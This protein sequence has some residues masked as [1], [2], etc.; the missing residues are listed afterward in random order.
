MIPIIRNNYYIFYIVVVFLKGGRDL[1]KMRSVQL[2]NDYRIAVELD[3]GNQ[4]VN[5]L[6]RIA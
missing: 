1:S 2:L 3:N 4:L 6:D 5:E